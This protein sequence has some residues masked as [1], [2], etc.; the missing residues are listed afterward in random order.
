MSQ[1]L[2]EEITDEQGKLLFPIYRITVKSVFLRAGPSELAE[3]IRH[4]KKGTEVRV[5][6]EYNRAD[7][8]LW[9]EVKAKQDNEELHGWVYAI[10]TMKPVKD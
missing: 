6:N 10:G 9:F 7:K 3:K 8:Y 4:L 5:L 1:N 2:F